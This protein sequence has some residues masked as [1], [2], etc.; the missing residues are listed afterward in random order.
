MYLFIKALSSMVKNIHYIYKN[1]WTPFKLMDLAISATPVT[2]SCIKSSTQP[3]N[4]H[5]Q[6]L[7]VKWHYWRAQWLSTWHHHRMPPFQ[8]VSQISA[9]LE[10]PRATLSAVIVKWKWKHLEE[11]TPQQR[12]GTISHEAPNKQFWQHSLPPSDLPQEIT[13]AQELF[14]LSFMKWVSMA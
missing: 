10:L 9:L 8:Q 11:T 2:G 12:R 3:C 13:S 4:L 5:R 14:V 7:A 6:T 1:M